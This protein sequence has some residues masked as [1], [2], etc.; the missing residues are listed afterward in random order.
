MA[1][2]LK[3]GYPGGLVPSPGTVSWLILCFDFYGRLMSEYAVRARNHESEF[4]RSK[5]VF[6]HSLTTCKF[7]LA[8]FGPKWLI[9]RPKIAKHAIFGDFGRNRPWSGRVKIGRK[10]LFRSWRPLRQKAHIVRFLRIIW[11]KIKLNS[12]IFGHFGG[13]NPKSVKN[14]RFWRSQNGH[15]LGPFLRGSIYGFKFW[16]HFMGW[17]SHF[18]GIGSLLGSQKRTTPLEGGSKVLCTEP[19]QDPFV[20][21]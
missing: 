4:T 14:G 3:T 8:I 16:A 21:V 20:R 18:Y 11:S 9:L 10:D 17:I 15:K 1:P 5:A 7:R 6:S 12:L 19:L 13:Q 2:V